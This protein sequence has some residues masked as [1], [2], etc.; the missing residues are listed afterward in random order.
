MARVKGVEI[1]KDKRVPIA[2]QSIY[3]IGLSI[4]KKICKEAGIDENTKVKDLT[5]EQ[6]EAIRK[7][8]G[9]ETTEGDLRREIKQ[10]IDTKKE[11]GSY[12]GIRHR[13]GLPVRGQKTNN[14]CSNSK[15]A[16]K[17]KTVANKKK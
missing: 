13:R 5:K 15:K 17:R 9:E 10:N 2:L 16:G 6:L 14:N 12:E 3:G 8:V 4:A 1:P 11:I 7:L